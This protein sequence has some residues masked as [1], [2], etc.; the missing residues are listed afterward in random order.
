MELWGTID[1]HFPH[2]N[3]VH[4]ERVCPFNISNHASM[5]PRTSEISCKSISPSCTR[6]VT[7]RRVGMR[8]HDNDAS[9]CSMS[10]L[11]GSS[12]SSAESSPAAPAAA[13]TPS[14]CLCTTVHPATKSNMSMPAFA[15]AIEAHEMATPRSPD[16][17][18]RERCRSRGT[19]EVTSGRLVGV[20]LV[21]KHM[22][23]SHGLWHVWGEALPFPFPFSLSRHPSPPS[24]LLC[25]PSHTHRRRTP[26]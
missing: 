22:H 19:D 7:C 20:H 17:G 21:G 11:V 16:R 8:A 18:W 1:S 4:S 10:S 23:V 26:G 15:T 9:A 3:K 5:P 13:P 25:L 6:W 2:V 14:R 24:T 12:T